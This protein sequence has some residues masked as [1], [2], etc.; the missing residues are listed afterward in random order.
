MK[1]LEKYKRFQIQEVWIWKDNKFSI[2]HLKDKE[3]EQISQS[4]LLPQ[5]DFKFLED[6]VLISS[7]LEA[8][9]IFSNGIK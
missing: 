2:Y 9:K 7:K 5:L 3:Y 8:I 6:C 1:K 4:E